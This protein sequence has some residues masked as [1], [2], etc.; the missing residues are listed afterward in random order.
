VRPSVAPDTTRAIIQVESRGGDP[1]STILHWSPEQGARVTS[2]V[3]DQAAALFFD[4]PLRDPDYLSNMKEGGL[5][6]GTKDR[7][8]VQEERNYKTELDSMQERQRF[9]RPPSNP[10][11]Q[12]SPRRGARAMSARTQ[13]PVSDKSIGSVD[14]KSSTINSEKLSVVLERQQPFVVRKEEVETDAA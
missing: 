14:Q 2:A 11:T 1:W 10:S 9:G 6:N 3:N 8:P 4:E 7:F 12:R 5:S 13:P